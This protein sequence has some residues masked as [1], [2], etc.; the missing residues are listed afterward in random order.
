MT[1]T[2]P[3]KGLIEALGFTMVFIIVTMIAIYIFSLNAMAENTQNV[4]V[5]KNVNFNA[6]KIRIRTSATRIMVDKLW[7]A[8]SVTYGKYQDQKAYTVISKF[9]SS[10]PGED[11]WLNGTRVDYNDTETDISN[12]I[13]TVMNNSYGNKPYMVQLYDQN[14]AV[15]SVGQVSEYSRVSYPIAVQGGQGRITI[16]YES[17]GVLNVR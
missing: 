8:D 12:Y 13:G 15:L 9:L 10:S 3:R 5:D 11:I 17:G 2:Q 4:N 7:R 1:H 14:G 6:E 16:Y